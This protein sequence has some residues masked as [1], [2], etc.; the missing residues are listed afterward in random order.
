M[1]N[2]KLYTSYF[3]RI[4]EFNQRLF[5]KSKFSGLLF[6][7]KGYAIH[8]VNKKIAQEKEHQ[9]ENIKQLFTNQY[10]YDI[11]HLSVIPEE[12]ASIYLCK[13]LLVLTIWRQP[14]I[15]I[16]ISFK[17]MCSLDCFALERQSQDVLSKEKKNGNKKET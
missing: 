3:K 1:L 11:F 9:V 6:S 14:Y 12:N 16:N 15:Y 10:R 2:K 7:Y 4:P 8:F 17:S 5:E 13:H